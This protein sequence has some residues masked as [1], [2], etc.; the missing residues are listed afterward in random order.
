MVKINLELSEKDYEM[1]LKWLDLWN[2]IYALL[3]D[4]VDRKYKKP[5]DKLAELIDKLLEF[6]DNDLMKRFFKRELSL[7]EEKKYEK[8]LEKW[9]TFDVL[10]EYD[11]YVVYNLTWID[12]DEVE[13]EDYD[14]ITDEEWD[15]RDELIKRMLW[16]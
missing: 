15:E 11:N 8:L 12:L 7:E 13:D 5:A 2:T 10:H 4:F 16:K 6:S 1:L 14:G 9:D 3:S